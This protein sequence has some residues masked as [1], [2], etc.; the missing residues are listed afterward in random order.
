MGLVL[1]STDFVDQS[2]EVAVR[3]PPRQLFQLQWT[4]Q[5]YRFGIAYNQLPVCMSWVSLA[6]PLSYFAPEDVAN[7]LGG[8]LGE[9]E[10]DPYRLDSGCCIKTVLNRLA[11]KK[12]QRN[13]GI[14]LQRLEQ[15]ASA[16]LHAA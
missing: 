1:G 3:R 6:Q 2:E 4:G 8:M 7:C 9:I 13:H 16:L 10:T 15:R 11:D 14:V 12:V 5:T